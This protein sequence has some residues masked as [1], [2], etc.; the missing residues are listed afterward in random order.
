MS[1]I[2]MSVDPG[3]ADTGVIVWQDGKIIIK[4]RIKTNSKT[5]MTKRVRKIVRELEAIFFTY[6]PRVV[7]VED[8]RVYP[9]PFSIRGQ[10]TLRIV[11]ALQALTGD[12]KIIDPQKWRKWDKERK[13][14]EYLKNRLTEE[15]D[16]ATILDND[17]HLLDAFYMLM[18]YLY[19]KQGKR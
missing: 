2:Y 14:A 18:A 3:I 19:K 15:K 17:E 1:N 5:E 4:K 7:L 13:T 16:W 9:H 6:C 12:S 8:Y 11:G 10:D